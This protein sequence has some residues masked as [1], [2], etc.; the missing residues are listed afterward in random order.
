MERLMQR[1]KIVSQSYNRLEHIIARFQEMH[2]TP[3]AFDEDEKMAYRDSLI[4][5]FEFS[6]DVTWKF[7]K[8]LLEEKYG[9][10][11]ASPKKVFQECAAQNII[12]QEESREFLA[13]VDAR[14]ATSH[15]Y[16]EEM[17]EKVGLK[18][19]SF[20]DVMKTVFNRVE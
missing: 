12:T 1:K 11:V 4:K 8:D 17:A 15:T 3:E 7:F 14:N 16:D 10:K 2:K 19:I 18:I 6:C 20:Y 5:R 9:I 13:M